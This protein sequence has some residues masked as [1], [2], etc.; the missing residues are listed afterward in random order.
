MKFKLTVLE[1]KDFVFGSLDV[2][3]AGC[4]FPV[5]PCSLAFLKQ[6]PFEIDSYPIFKNEKW[7]SGT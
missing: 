3:S 4:C 7:N 6:H 2:E 5:K 1:S